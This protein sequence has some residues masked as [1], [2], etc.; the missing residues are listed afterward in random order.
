MTTTS[1][2]KALFNTCGRQGLFGLKYRCQQRVHIG[3]RVQKKIHLLP[4]EDC[5]MGREFE[6]TI[7]KSTRSNPLPRPPATFIKISC[8]SAANGNCCAILPGMLNKNFSKAP[9]SEENITQK[10]KGTLFSP[11]QQQNEGMRE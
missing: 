9:P 1:E 8:P 2:L 3:R 7:C 6:F 10:G 11:T 5:G 4:K